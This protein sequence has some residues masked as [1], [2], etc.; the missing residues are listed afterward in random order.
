MSVIVPTYI[1][2]LTVTM[3]LNDTV[4]LKCDASGTENYVNPVTVYRLEAFI[5]L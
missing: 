4:T 3:I 5:C 2:V 1:I